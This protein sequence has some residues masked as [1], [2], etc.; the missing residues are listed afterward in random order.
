MDRCFPLICREKHFPRNW[1]QT[2]NGG[3]SN[4]PS[5]YGNRQL[6]RKTQGPI[7][8]NRRISPDHLSPTARSHTRMSGLIPPRHA[9][10]LA[11]RTSYQSQQSR[12]SSR[13][14]GLPNGRSIAIATMPEIESG[15]GT[16]SIIFG[17]T[18]LVAKVRH[19]MSHATDAAATAMPTSLRRLVPYT[20]HQEYRST[21]QPN[22]ATV[23]LVTLAHRTPRVVL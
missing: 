8:Q 16:A 6:P 17:T 22:A 19:P 7:I 21:I 13:W 9:A 11:R 2:W 23:N 20:C 4:V 18:T 10:I 1:I 5:G 14:A 15:I 3:T 12:V